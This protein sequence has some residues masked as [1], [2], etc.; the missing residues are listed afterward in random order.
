MLFELYYQITCYFFTK[1]LLIQLSL[2]RKTDSNTAF[3]KMKSKG[4][5]GML[6][7]KTFKVVIYFVTD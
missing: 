4:N 5:F 7:V 6:P 2:I 3:M 1:L